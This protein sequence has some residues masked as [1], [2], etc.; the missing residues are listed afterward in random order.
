MNARYSMTTVMSSMAAL[1]CVFAL[2]CAA[3]VGEEPAEGA[4]PLPVM[5]GEAKAPVT[6][7]KLRNGNEL[8]FYS[9]PEEGSAVL[10]IGNVDNGPSVT[11]RPELRDASPEE[12]FWAVSEP[13]TPVPEGLAGRLSESATSLLNDRAQGWLIKTMG[14]AL[15][16][17]DQ[18]TS[19]VL[20]DEAYCD[21]P[22]P[23][24]SH[25][26]LFNRTG[27]TTWRSGRASRYKVGLC[28]EEGTVHDQLTYTSHN[29]WGACGFAFPEAIAW[30]FDISAGG[31]INWVW[32]AGS[33]GWWRTFTHTT[34]Q[35]SGDVFD[36]GQRWN[37]EPSCL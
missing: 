6:V 22:P 18:C 36:H 21:E 30:T 8:R 24:D 20:F 14:A 33:D 34:T 3:D 37:Y 35:A 15:T 11:R 25:K 31:S 19:D 29:P 5:A 28:V 32:S 23:Y 17:A 13:D 7:L 4:A 1:G 27:D 10:E 26:C 9:D 16:I 2:G 12:I